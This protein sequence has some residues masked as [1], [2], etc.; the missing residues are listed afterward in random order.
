MT[1]ALEVNDTGLVLAGAAGILAEEPGLAM[2]DGAAP[3][4]GLP[5]A[6]RARLKPLFGENRYWQELSETA[7]PRPTAAA[8]T[9]AELAYAQLKSLAAEHAAGGSEVLLAVPPWYRREQLGLLLGIVR[10]AGLKGVGLVD[11]AVAASALQPVPATLL[12]LDMWL[13]RVVVSVLEHTGEL[14]R[15]R[16]EILPQHG[17]LALQQ[18][19]LAMLAAT[20]VKK[21]RFDPLHQARTEQLLCDGLP[22]W[23]ESLRTQP[24]V[25]V[26]IEHGGA[27]HAIEVSAA[28][29]AA[30]AEPVYLGWMRVLQQLRPGSAPLHLRMSQR[31]AA[32][33][34]LG[35][36]LGGIRDSEIVVL[37]RGAAALGALACE[38]AIRREDA[39]LALVQ[40]LPVELQE[41]VPRT[42]AAAP[43]MDSEDRPTHILRGSQAHRIRRE[44]LVVGAA[45]AADGRSLAID[46][47]PGV[48]RSHFAVWL[49]GGTVWLEDRS[50]YGTFVNG[51]RVGGRV[52]LHPGDRVRA[53]SPGTELLLLRVEEDDGTP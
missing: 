28:E 26:E 10:E 27:R 25:A 30:A 35:E 34:G 50:T 2:L 6:A 49:D 48:S 38:L 37:P 8:A 17:W 31:F 41:P 33:P 16:F 29:F 52:R 24:A 11:A 40:R 47:G 15:S 43:E 18:A 5:A 20:F 19:W 23:L 44:P 12:Q 32:L 36:Y 14:R 42:P 9:F 4:T 1:L 51:T 39:A 53:G 22:A 7:L 21:T 13:H 45:P 3:E 46:A